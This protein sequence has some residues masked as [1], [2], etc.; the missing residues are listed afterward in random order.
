MIPPETQTGFGGLSSL[1]GGTSSLAAMGSRMFG[2]TNA[3]E[4]VLLGI[5]NSRSALVKVINEFKLVDYYEI[6]DGN[7]D[8]VLKAF[9]N[10][11]VSWL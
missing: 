11:I 10:D 7:M 3:S 6:S 9:R 5:I 1:L 8:K 2:L 4:D